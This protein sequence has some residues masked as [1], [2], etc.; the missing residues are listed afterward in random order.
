M[1]A[2]ALGPGRGV[3]M[4]GTFIVSFARVGPRVRPQAL[5]RFVGLSLLTLP[6]RARGGVFEQDSARVEVFAN[7]IRFREI[8]RGPGGAA[9]LNELLDLLDRH[10]RPFVFRSA[11]RQDPQH[12][13]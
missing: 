5:S 2:L 4:S 7:S 10:G 6:S 11:E 9:R 12:A 13:I 1:I 3:L 8:A